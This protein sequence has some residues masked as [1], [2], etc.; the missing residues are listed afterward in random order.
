MTP[1]R[2]NV[3]GPLDAIPVP[4]LVAAEGVGIPIGQSLSSR[5]SNVR[6][7]SPFAQP[8]RV[9]SMRRSRS[10]GDE[11]ICEPGRVGSMNGCPT[12]S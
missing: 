2:G 11:L 7:T 12:A 10:E 5:E 4:V 8:N 3:M 6:R 1:L 9:V